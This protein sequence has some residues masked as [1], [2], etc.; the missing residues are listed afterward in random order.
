MLLAAAL[1]AD[2]SGLRYRL[3][4]MCARKE[5]VLREYAD[6]LNCPFWTTEAR[7]LCRRDN[8][9]VVAVY[10][11]DHLHAEHCTWALEA[12]KHVVCTKPMVT[13]LD[14]ARRLVE[15]VRR[16]GCKFLR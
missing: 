8:V 3:C 2:V 7:E 14:D 10:S 11:P 12:G 9:D 1:L 6:R 5:P 13:R 15:L 4:G 16:S